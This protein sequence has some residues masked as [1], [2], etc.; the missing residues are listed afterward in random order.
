MARDLAWIRDR[1]E[2]ILNANPLQADANYTS[3]QLNFGVNEAC[4]Q[5]LNKA[6]SETN[7]LHFL[8]SVDFTWPASQ[9][10]F[11]ITGSDI[12]DLLVYRY[13]LVTN[14]QLEPTH[15]TFDYRDKTTLVWHSRRNGPAGDETIRALHWPK[16][17]ELSLDTDEPDWIAANHRNLLAWSAAILLHE[18]AYNQNAPQSW[19]ARRDEYRYAWY[20]TVESRPMS[21]PARVTTQTESF[22]LEGSESL[23]FDYWNYD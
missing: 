1:A 15:I 10:T 5:E 19:Y 18:I 22:N 3:S 13:L 23:G 20:K 7:P 9:R 2:N 14:A 17:N 16:A 6:I 12:E 21:D 11:A 8:R 4:D